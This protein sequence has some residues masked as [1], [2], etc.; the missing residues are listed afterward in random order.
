MWQMGII[1]Y[2]QVRVRS[3]IKYNDSIHQDILYKCVVAVNHRKMA[4]QHI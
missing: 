4:A 1:S 2:R 3:P